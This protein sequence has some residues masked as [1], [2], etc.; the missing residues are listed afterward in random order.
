MDIETEL[1]AAENADL[2]FIPGR[3]ALLENWKVPRPLEPAS[4]ALV[5]LRTRSLAIDTSLPQLALFLCPGVAKPGYRHWR[6]YVRRQGHQRRRTPIALASR[7][8]RIGAAE[9]RNELSESRAA[10]SIS[11]RRLQHRACRRG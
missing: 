2:A 3:Q 7:G 4:T 5:V 6:W 10:M 1:R 8:N 11:P 9:Q